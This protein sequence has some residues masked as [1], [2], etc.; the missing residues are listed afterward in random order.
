MHFKTFRESSDS[1]SLLNLD[2]AEKK[3]LMRVDYNCPVESGRVTNNF[4]IKESLETINFLLEKGVNKI[5]LITHFERPEGKFNP[6]F[7]LSPVKSELEKLL[8]EEVLMPAYEENYESY[9]KKVRDLEGK[10]C[11]LEN[12]RFWPEEET[13]ENDFSK[14]LSLGNDFYINEAFSASHRKHAS[15]T[16]VSTFL[17]HYAGLRMAGEVR[18]IYKLITSSGSPSIALVGGAKI[19]TKV[20]VLRALSKYYDKLILGGKIGIEYEE[21]V[22]TLGNDEN[23]IK[24]VEL[25]LGYINEEKLDISPESALKFSDVLNKAKKILWNGPVGKFEEPQYR[26]GSEA[27]A[28]AISE[29]TEAFRLVGGGDTIALLDEIGLRERV[30]F[31]STG[32]GAMLEYIADDTLTGIEKLEF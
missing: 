7:S 1:P 9:L 21:Y 13:N 10:I 30:G 22:K 29:N 31:V 14:A 17:P 18:E 11:L 28:K 25:P 5:T 24:K 15:V 8:G 12:I 16:G 3:I 6:I 26:T 27:I 20:P 23:W 4:R 32:G 19:E 2:L